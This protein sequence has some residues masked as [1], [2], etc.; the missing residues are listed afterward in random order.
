MKK[1]KGII[2]LISA[3]LLLITGMIPVNA[4]AER[5]VL[6]GDIDEDG[7]LSSSDARFALRCAVG[8]EIYT[9]GHLKTGDT[10]GDSLLT[11]SDARDILRYCVGLDTPAVLSVQVSDADYLE[12]IN[13]PQSDGLF[14]WVLPTSPE[15][16]APPDSFTFTVYGF[17][18]GVGLSQYGALSLEDGGYTYD[19]ILSHYY[20]GTEISTLEEIPEAVIYPSYEYNE[21]TGSSSWVEK[22]HPIRELL[23]RIVYQEIYGITENGKYREAL[24][25][26][27]LCI[28]TNLA[29]Y[30]FYI[31]SRWDVGI[32]STLDY[33][34]IPENLKSLV[35]EVIGQYITVEG[36]DSPIQAVY[37]GLAAG[38]TAASESIWGGSLSYLTAVP[39][40]FDMQREGFVSQKTYSSEE[41]RKLITA[42]DS[43]I[44]LSD[45]PS[46]WLRITE[47]T[48]SMDE[49]RGYVVKIQVGNKILK[50]YNQFLMGILNNELRSPCFTITY[51]PPE[52]QTE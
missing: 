26:L 27:T 23:V 24:K 52:T 47:H 46:E 14:E 38:M 50:G 44:V 34:R 1:I 37:S 32:A 11:S 45:D 5:T 39:S 48:G 6:F 41:L 31:T 8:L 19:K 35:D 17:G 28:F 22:E 2:S 7:G 33:E 18:H 16:N 30:D 12:I 10:D 4:Y 21:E 36:S 51:T 13:K 9:L 20:T 40:P 15:V 3:A 43:T 25:A 42:Y 49:S 29:Y